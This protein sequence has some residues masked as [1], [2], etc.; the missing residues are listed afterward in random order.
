MKSLTSKLQRTA[1]S[2][3][4][5]EQSLFYGVIPTFAKV[6]GQFLNERDRWKSSEI[7]LKSQLHKHKK[8]L[9]RLIEQHGNY[10]Q[11]TNSVLL[12]KLLSNFVLKTLRKENTFR[13][14][15]KNKKLRNLR[16]KQSSYNSS[17]VTIINLSSVQWTDISP[18][19]HALKQ[20]FVDKNK[21][22]KKD[23]AVEFETLRCSVEKDISP[24][25]EE[26]FHEFLRSA[27]HTFTQKIYR[28]KDST[29]NMLKPFQRNKDIV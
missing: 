17:K 23:I 27:T 14:S 2:I 24:D 15:T 3:A 11:I 20:C 21:Y 7:I 12:Y 9:S 8:L 13:L 22:I 10:R 25:D 26:N 16:P 1:S 28:T 18:L 19:E 29:Y 6:K 5:I 4:F